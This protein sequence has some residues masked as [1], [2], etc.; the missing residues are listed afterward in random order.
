MYAVRKIMKRH[1]FIIA[2]NARLFFAG[3][4]LLFTAAGVNGS[5]IPGSPE[6]VKLHELWKPL[7]ASP[8]KQRGRERFNE[9]STA[10]S[11][12]GG[13]ILN[14]AGFGKGTNGRRWHWSQGGGMDYATKEIPRAE[15]A[16]L[17]KTFDPEKFDAD[18]WVSIAKAAGMKYMV[19]TSK[20]HDGF[21]LFDS[22]V[23]T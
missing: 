8:A 3:L 18:E 4:F 7:N 15:Y 1:F 6:M 10:C 22:D 20:H 19:I 21:A 16:T 5:G 23:V 12:I 14:V 9:T 13:C 11:F 2:A 17:A